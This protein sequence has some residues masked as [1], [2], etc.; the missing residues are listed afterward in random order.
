MKTNGTVI[1]VSKTSWPFADHERVRL[2]LIYGLKVAKGGRRPTTRAVFRNLSAPNKE[3]ILLEMDWLSL[4]RLTPGRIFETSPHISD[5]IIDGNPIWIDIP[6][7]QKVEVLTLQDA[8]TQLK[9]KT[10]LEAFSHDASLPE[11][12]VF[13]W[14]DSKGY[15]Y[16]LP[17]LE[18]IRK[19]FVRSP[20][21]A[22]SIIMYDGLDE[23][24]QDH[25][26]QDGTLYIEF[27]KI[28]KIGD[29]PLLSLIV[30]KPDLLDG[31]RSVAKHLPKASDWI[32]VDS[33]WFFDEDISITATYKTIGSTYWIQEILDIEGF[34]IPFREI[35]PTHPNY[36]SQAIDD[37][38]PPRKAAVNNTE[39]TD[40]FGVDLPEDTENIILEPTNNQISRPKK[41]IHIQSTSLS[42]LNTVEVHPDYIERKERPTIIETE[43]LPVGQDSRS[44][45]NERQG[46][47]S[48]GISSSLSPTDAEEVG[49]GVKEPQDSLQWNGLENFVEA[50]NQTV[51]ELGGNSYL[52]W[53]IP[54]TA[55]KKPKDI[56]SRWF[57]KM[58]NKEPRTWCL[59]KISFNNHDFYF[60]EVGRDNNTKFSLATIFIKNI[61]PEPMSSDWIE[62][63]IINNGHWD[64]DALSKNIPGIEFLPHQKKDADDWG[65]YLA[66]K[67]RDLLRDL[68]ISKA[69]AA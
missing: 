46:H 14:R 30:S 47:L 20:E 32:A 12:R 62:N 43:E 57:L 13:H 26:I 15:E 44:S 63:M 24:V 29:I 4:P 35:V 16:W 11:T 65:T 1:R 36:V 68:E 37:T 23:L 53:P 60:L 28:P 34:S 66:K 56:R 55:L 51:K 39:S 17:V 10:L 59:A 45:I 2:E 5:G 49:V 3:L 61:N 69:C 64:R 52:S 54:E 27:T 6:S 42:G 58:E 50:M 48:D 7:G 18:L 22:R 31:W 19:M 9:S 38:L 41:Y 21:L 8:Q 67:I 25:C 40:D 33:T